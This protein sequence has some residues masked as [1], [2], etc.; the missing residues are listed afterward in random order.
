L[1]IGGA[2]IIAVIGLLLGVET[3]AGASHSAGP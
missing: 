2:V 3:D 1:L